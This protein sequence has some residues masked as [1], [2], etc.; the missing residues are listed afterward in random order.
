[1]PQQIV[2]A[3]TVQEFSELPCWGCGKHS[4]L[5]LVGQRSYNQIV[6]RYADQFLR[7]GCIEQCGGKEDCKLQRARTMSSLRSDEERLPV[8]VP[9]LV[10]NLTKI[11]NPFQKLPAFLGTMC[12]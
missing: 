8:D 11:A 7:S 6:P 12:C 9:T 4:S 2:C 1:M 10:Q 3:E 5:S